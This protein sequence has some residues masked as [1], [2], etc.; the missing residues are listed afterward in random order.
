MARPRKRR[1]T[2][3]SRKTETHKNDDDVYDR[4]THVFSVASDQKP[5]KRLAIV[6]SLPLDEV[7]N[8]D[9]FKIQYPVE[10]HDFLNDD[11]P[12]VHSLS[13]NWGYGYTPCYYLGAKNGVERYRLKVPYVVGGPHPTYEIMFDHIKPRYVAKRAF[14][15]EEKA[16]I[17]HDAASIIAEIECPGRFYMA[18]KL[19]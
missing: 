17:S 2:G 1:K 3:S 6:G 18:G 16:G 8:S 13:I 14:M 12:L 4:Y 11:V 7:I 19:E 9:V 5:E 15:I 10:L